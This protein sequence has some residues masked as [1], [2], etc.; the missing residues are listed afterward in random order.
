MDEGEG[1][2]VKGESRGSVEEDPMWRSPFK[3]FFRVKY[4]FTGYFLKQLSLCTFEVS[5]MMQ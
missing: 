2:K 3:Y 4:F 5:N 1:R